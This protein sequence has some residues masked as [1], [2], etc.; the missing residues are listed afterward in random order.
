M[1]NKSIR[2]DLTQ[3][4]FGKARSKVM[5]FEENNCDG[6]EF[7]KGLFFAMMNQ[8]AAARRKGLVDLVPIYEDKPLEYEYA[9]TPSKLQMTT[10][11]GTVCVVIDTDDTMRIV[12]SGVGIRLYTKIPFM[13]META[14]M[15]PGGLA[16]L[17][18]A[19]YRMDGGRFMFKALKGTITLDSVFNPT[20]NGPEDAKI[21]FLPAED[22]EFDIITYFM[23]PDEWGYIDAKPIGDSEAEVA[24]DFE[25]F[26]GGYPDVCQRWEELKNVCAYAVWLHTM[27]PSKVEL[28]PTLKSD[29]IYSNCLMG[30]W[31]E[32][33]KQALHALAMKDAD[34]AIGYIE[35]VFKH[36]VKG[37]LP[38]SVSTAKTHYQAAP[39]VFGLA[40][41][42]ILKKDGVSAEQ[43]KKLYA[44]MVENYEW[45]K[46]GHSFGEGRFS[47]N[48]R[49]EL[50]I[51]GLSYSAM[52]FPLETPDIY[53]LMAQYAKALAA[54]SAIVGDGREAEWKAVEKATVDNL[55]GL[56]DGESFNC[57]AAV[58]GRV[59]KTKSLLAYL[60]I[61][62]GDALPDDII[63]KLAADLGD[64]EKFLSAVGFR[65][66]SKQSKYFNGAV[67]GSGAV[68]MW[69]QQLIVGG[70][71]ECDAELA[72]KAAEIILAGAEKNG[73]RDVLV[74]EGEQIITRPGNYINSTAAS[75]ILYI[76]GKLGN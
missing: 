44:P 53:A 29:M 76:A 56:W 24:K 58:S 47:Y 50:A 41:N 57:K 68:V 32:T 1:P 59:F 61:V 8:G 48:H 66:E 49:D 26:A 27:G 39:P 60:P 9:A 19:S 34:K 45:W 52:E 16:D 42:E 38:A 25:E 51:A 35:G 30:A 71:F 20:I 28:V 46:K 31:A 37:M 23:N 33:F 5:V 73:V 64:E 72:A 69:L 2:L 74:S 7:G 3:I 6:E 75:A 14:T 17:N 15:L 55:I 70:L 54:L 67:E 10:A 4:P 62:L 18:L 65:S 40:V 63:K 43:L 21:E 36:T 13:A 22:G 12:G 11:K